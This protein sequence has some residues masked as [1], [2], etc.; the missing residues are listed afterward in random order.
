MKH[1]I[2]GSDVKQ[3][4]LRIRDV[5]TVNKEFLCQLDGAMGDGDIGITMSKG[6][7]SIVA[8]INEEDESQPGR[9]IIKAGTI[10]A[11]AAPS[12]MGTLMATGIMRAGKEAGN[13]TEITPEDLVK[14][15]HAAVEGIMKRGK[16]QRGEKTA[17]DALI[18]AVEAIEQNVNDGKEISEVFKSAY[19]AALQGSESTKHMKSIHGRAGWYGEKSIGKE[20]PGA[21]ACMLVFKSISEYFD[22]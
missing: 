9:M 16:A 11:G 12:T 17:L 1:V 20:D 7:S 15:G 21:V 5:M 2:T 8:G 13:A 22:Q 4:F 6:Y 14:M 3:I 18:P 10:M 19:L